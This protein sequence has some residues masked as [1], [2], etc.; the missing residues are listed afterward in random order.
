MTET[1]IRFSVPAVLDQEVERVYPRDTSEA[2][3]NESVYFDTK[4]FALR[5]NGIEF[6]IRRNSQGWKQTVK[7]AASDGAPFSRAE[8]EIA[9]D[10]ATP[11]LTHLA[12]HLPTNLKGVLAGAPIRPV[13]RTDIQRRRLVVPRR[14]G[15]IEIAIDRGRLIAGN[16]SV[17]VEDVEH[18]LLRGSTDDLARACLSFL[19]EVPAG[20]QTEGK[21][22]RGFRLLT[23][24]QAPPVFSA[25]VQLTPDTPFPEAVQTLLRS[26]YGQILGNHAPMITTTQPEAVHQMRI[27]IRRLRSI[28]SA[29]SPALDLFGIQDMLNETKDLFTRLGDVRE[30]DVFI[31]ATVADVPFGDDNADLRHALIAR[32]DAFRQHRRADVVDYLTSAAF[33]RL[34][35]RWLG[36]IEGG[37]GLR[38][39]RIDRAPLERPVHEFAA[40][41]LTA[42]NKKMF[43]RG[44]KACG[45]TMADWHRARIAAK[46]V[47]YAGG[48]LRDLLNPAE[49]RRIPGKAS[50]ARLQDDLGH[51]N[52]LSNVAPLLRRVRTDADAGTTFSRAEAF[53]E[54]WSRAQLPQA[55]RALRKTWKSFEKAS[56]RRA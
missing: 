32:V 46:K 26:A 36:W 29:F 17:A 52:D 1:E 35:V 40:R 6:R 12:D 56:R 15:E 18:E 49:A 13:F 55:V 19:D 8:H 4:K 7:A 24:D 38:Y 47:R 25:P 54:G 43:K 37:A 41:R 39:N 3:H 30:A 20:L 27:G 44:H 34:A 48:P 50:L 14:D 42:M 11:N 51:F 31:A 23:S 5:R 16:A 9:L 22:A 21:A 33:A 53:C 2:E 28:L 45:G 10:G